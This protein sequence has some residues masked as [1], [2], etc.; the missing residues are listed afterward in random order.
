MSEIY[1]VSEIMKCVSNYSWFEFSSGNNLYLT[2]EIFI[3]LRHKNTGGWFEVYHINNFEGDYL[4]SS[5]NIRDVFDWCYDNLHLQI[6]Y[7]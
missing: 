7:Y 5:Q 1:N 4:F 3:T 6:L 2:S